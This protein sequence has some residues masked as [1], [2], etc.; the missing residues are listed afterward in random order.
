V[1]AVPSLTVK[2]RRLWG[3]HGSVSHA[4]AEIDVIEDI[5]APIGL[6]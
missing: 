5:S 1:L 3:P 2:F 4:N 6:S